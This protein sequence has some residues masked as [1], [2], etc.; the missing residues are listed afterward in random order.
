MNPQPERVAVDTG[1]RTLG[2]S[3]IY[4]PHGHYRATHENRLWVPLCNR[5]TKTAPAQ[6]AN[7]QAQVEPTC[8]KCQKILQLRP[9]AATV[10]D[11]ALTAI[12]EYGSMWAG[13]ED[14]KVI[15][16]RFVIEDLRG[17]VEPDRV[18]SMLDYYLTPVGATALNIEPLLARRKRANRV[19][20]GRVR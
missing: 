11:A 16:A 20:Y 8:T 15:E 1:K 7:L 4:V 6:E 2:R 12:D 19:F 17:Q 13:D 18:R 14:H 5:Y 9:L 3:H 10:R